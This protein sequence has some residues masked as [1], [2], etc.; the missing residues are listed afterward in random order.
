MLPCAVPE[1]LR[2]GEHTAMAACRLHCKFCSAPR[3]FQE[4]SILT[5]QC[6]VQ[7]RQLSARGT[8]VLGLLAMS[9]SN[10]H[11]IPQLAFL[12]EWPRAR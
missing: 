3:C 4:L 2:H 10:E 5:C 6:A 7:S 9:G 12:Q 11:L 8:V 1:A